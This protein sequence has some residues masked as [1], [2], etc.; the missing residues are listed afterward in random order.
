MK[1]STTEDTEDAEELLVFLGV[2]RVLCAGEFD[3]YN[4]I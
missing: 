3:F 1:R 4:A 2:L